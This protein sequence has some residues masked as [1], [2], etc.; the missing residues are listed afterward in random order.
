MSSTNFH[1]IVWDDEKITKM[2]DF[3]S[4][5]PS[6]QNMYFSKMNGRGVLKYLSER[7]A[8]SGKRIL[9]YGSGPAF[10]LEHILALGLDLKY[11]ALDNSEESIKFIKETFSSEKRLENAFYV[12]SFPSQINETFDVIICCEVIEHLSDEH[13]SSMVQ[14]FKKLLKPG[15]YLLVTTPNDEN[16][17]D[18]TMACPEC[19]CVFHKWQHLR[20]WNKATISKFFGEASF[21]TV[22]VDTITISTNPLQR[23]KSF[24]QRSASLFGYPA[25]K[26]ANLLYLGKRPA[27]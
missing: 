26:P 23:I 5:N 6:S 21:E 12:D 17:N 2:W 3:H 25:P 14:E 18:L 13:L 15:G 8:L 27:L 16:L 10:L 11:N 19:G 9:D 22:S 4:K 20:S 24:L 1:N 7:V